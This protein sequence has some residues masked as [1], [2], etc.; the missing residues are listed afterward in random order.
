MTETKDFCNRDDVGRLFRVSDT[1]S[2]EV[3]HLLFYK[4]AAWPSPPEDGTEASFHSFWDDNIRNI[5]ELL[6]PFSKSIRDDPRQTNTPKLR[7]DYGLLLGGVCL[8]RGEEKSKTSRGDP[9][10]SLSDG[11]TWIYSPAPYVFGELEDYSCIYVR[12]S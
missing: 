3:L 8:F 5:L 12:F 11:L 10:A 4:A 6:V 2:S 9:K 1:E 7:P